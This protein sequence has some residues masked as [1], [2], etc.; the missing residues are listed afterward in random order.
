[1]ISISISAHLH[2]VANS[3][4]MLTADVLP[5]G[6]LLLVLKLTCPTLTSCVWLQIARCEN[7][8][9]SY[10]TSGPVSLGATT[11]G[12]GSC[13]STKSGENIVDPM[14]REKFHQDKR[15]EH[16]RTYHCCLR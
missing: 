15:H 1:M 10:A 9:N 3:N 11:S 14:Y 7:E 5:A 16:Q 2:R 6:R 4:I 8:E 13:W 12:G